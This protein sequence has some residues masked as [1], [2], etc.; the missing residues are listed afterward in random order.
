MS[1][2]NSKNITPS[3]SREKSPTKLKPQDA[4]PQ[5][6][7]EVKALNSDLLVDEPTPQPT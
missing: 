6:S 4:T 7:I 3:K 1:S 2:K 5:K